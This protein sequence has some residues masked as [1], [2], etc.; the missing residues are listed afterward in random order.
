[1][2]FVGMTTNQ[3]AT[4][5]LFS[6]MFGLEPQPFMFGAQARPGRIHNRMPLPGGG[7]RVPSNHWQTLKPSIDP[8]D[9]QIWM[10]ATR[11]FFSR[12]QEYGLWT[13]NYR[14]LERGMQCKSSC[15]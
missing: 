14:E 15:A 9:W 4:A 8:L 5:C 2:A 10:S 13:E 11:I 12:L 6:R 3:N 1:M 7:E